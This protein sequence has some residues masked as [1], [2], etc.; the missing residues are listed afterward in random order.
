MHINKEFV[1]DGEIYPESFFEIENVTAFLPDYLDGIEERIEDML[2]CLD[3]G[4]PDGELGR[5]CET[6]RACPLTEECWEDMPAHHVMTL[7][8]GSALGERLLR[9]GILA[10]S[11]IPDEEPLN[12]K[13]EIQRECVISGLPYYNRAE[14]RGFLKQLAYPLHFLD[15]ETFRFAIPVYNGTKPYQQIIFQF[16]LH[17]CARDGDGGTHYGY[18]ADGQNDPRPALLRELRGRLGPAGSILAYNKSF[19]EERL[20][21]SAAAF[22]VE[23][24][25]IEGAV[26][27][28]LDLAAPFKGFLYYHPEQYGS[29]SQKK[30]LPALTG[31]SY[32][33]LNIGDGE[34]ASLKYIECN[35]GNLTEEARAKIR[36]D[37]VAYCGQDTKGMMEMVRALRRIVQK[38]I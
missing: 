1:R 3:G 30:V 5:R 36:N 4:E 18:L 2:V 6:P 35:F 25:W 17:V 8:Y 21:E 38:K 28:L 9:R 19:E 11:E 23:K 10:V 32:N 7:C 33:G 22:P 12:G 26:S 16:S 27:R 15:F 14:I 31:I 20:N 29:W 24:G 37:L 13:Q 34:T